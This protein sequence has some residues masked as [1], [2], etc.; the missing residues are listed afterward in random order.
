MRAIVRAQR[1]RAPSAAA[2]HYPG[3]RLFV[4]IPLAAAP[5]A[6]LE[7]LA[8]RLR[9][10][11]DFLRWVPPVSWHITL[12]FLGNATP[13]QYEQ[14]ITHLAEVRHTP[15]FIQLTEPGCFERAGIFH[16]GVALTPQFATL[17]GLVATAVARCSFTPE[18][19]PYHPHITL[20]RAKGNGRAQALHALHAQ[21]AHTPAF[22]R[23][24][25]G[26]FLLYESRLS[27]TG[28]EYEVRARFPLAA[29]PAAPSTCS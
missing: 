3:M 24:I 8:R 27:P 12:E 26:E 22:T 6:E 11:S 29:Q 17:H 16:T 25:A 20:A 4:G 10:H 1:H 2:L 19:R 14:L 28:A 9:P 21:L 13:Q 23:F 7:A 18:T 5:I 15:V